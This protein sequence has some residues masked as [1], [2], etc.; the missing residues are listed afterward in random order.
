MARC[1]LRTNMPAGAAGRVPEAEGPSGVAE[2]CR[3]ERSPLGT[4]LKAAAGLLVLLRAASA[5]G[6]AVQVR[7]AMFLAARALQAARRST[8]TVGWI[9]AARCARAEAM[10]GAY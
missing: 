6:T 9:G 8:E 3:R 5:A 4:L 2:R 10:H 7:E 1:S